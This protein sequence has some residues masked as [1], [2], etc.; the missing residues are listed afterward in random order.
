M[1]G[2]NVV[3]NYFS[4]ELSAFGLNYK[5]VSG[6]PQDE[7]IIMLIRHHI[8]LFLKC[9]TFARTLY[10]VPLHALLL[11]YVYVSVPIIYCSKFQQFL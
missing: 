11:I 3:T 9:F 10:I 8:S 5:K 4:A 7:R 6:N 2:S 1:D